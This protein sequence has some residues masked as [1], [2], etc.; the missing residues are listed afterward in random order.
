[1]SEQFSEP[2]QKRA[3]RVR[4]LNLL[5]GVLAAI[6][7]CILIVTVAFTLRSYRDAYDATERYNRAQADAAA[8][9]SVSDYLTDRARTFA[10]SGDPQAAFEYY[11]EVEATKQR[12][13]A[14]SDMEAL[15][16]DAEATRL[17]GE[18]LRISN[19]LAEIERYAM[20]LAIE[21]DGYELSAYPTAL[22]QTVLTDA[23]AALSREAQAEKARTLLFDEN[24]QTHKS[25]IRANVSECERTLIGEAARFQ[26][27]SVGRLGR[28]LVFDTVLTAMLLVIVIVVILCTKAL[29]LSPLHT[30]I[31]TIPTGQSIP[32]TGSDEL[33]YLIRAYN[34]AHERSKEH[35]DRLAYDAT[36]DHLTGLMNRAAF[37]E[38]RVNAHKRRQAMLLIDVDLFKEL[39]DS[40]GHDGGDRVLQKVAQTLRANFR[41]ED[42]LCRIG[43][44]E[45][46]VILLHTDRSLRS[47]IERK[48]EDIR[49]A[50]SD[51]A[52][53]LPRVTL[54]IGVAFCDSEN[55]TD[56]LYK[57][58][59]AALYV[60][61]EHGR[62][63]YAFFDDIKTD[64]RKD[65]KEC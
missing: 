50:L 38:H 44:D 35:Q 55:P 28:A 65:E 23:D 3:I 5:L 25:G 14:L 42:C 62:N 17:L 11:L 37:D 16:S 20:R 51:D 29:V 36:H 8:M 60:V 39:N 30:V 34:D 53:G 63:G 59:D 12:D 13:A 56:D 31:R 52:D 4:R 45:F 49:A 58:A 46:A 10:I 2:A 27:N 26:A 7:A 43:G 40:L 9:R 21:A 6:L 33:R 48:L 18:A 15:F 32:E 54:S 19:E 24:Y 1:M 22:Q 64:D 41:E 61:K 57:D 47:M